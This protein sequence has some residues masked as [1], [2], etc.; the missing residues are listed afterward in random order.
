MD[1]SALAD[2][3]LVA[4][5]RG[6]SRASLGAGRPKATLFRRV[7]EL[8]SS[9]DIRL[10]ER[11]ACTLKRAEEGR[12]PYEQTALRL[13]ELDETAAAITSG[14]QNLLGRLRISAPSL[15]S[16]T[17]IGRQAAGFAMRF[18]HVRLEVTSDGRSIDMIEE[19]K[20]S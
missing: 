7:S 2:F 19:P 1:L 13:T 16:Q 12:A 8:V 10:F 14:G 20:T 17:A 9:L 15:F 18:P 11:E 3:N 4:R 5:H 6:F